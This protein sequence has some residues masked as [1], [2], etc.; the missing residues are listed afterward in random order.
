MD[1]SFWDRV[2]GEDAHVY[3]T[4]PNDFLRAEAER[5]PPGPVL[6]LAEGEGRNAVFLAGRGHAVTA[7]DQ[8]AVGLAK[9][10]RLAAAT[11]VTLD[12]VRAD[13]AIYEPPADAFAG[14]VAIFAH[15]PAPARGAMYARAIRALR[16]GGCL[17]V[18]AYAPR[19]IGLGTGGPKDPAMLASLAELTAELAP[20]ELVIA[21]EV[22]RHVVEGRLH[23]GRAATL[24]LVGYR[25]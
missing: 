25:R 17:I 18:E 21:R 8:S 13:L 14:V 20:L 10:A 23:T 16:I 11:G 22:E 12:L 6:C 19:Q 9:A 3:G 4:T 5:L 7:V 24:Q 15:L 2:Y 1:S